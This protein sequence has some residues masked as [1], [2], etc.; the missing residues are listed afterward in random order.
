MV[1]VMTESNNINLFEEVFG[2]VCLNID[3][4]SKYPEEVQKALCKDIPMSEK[5]LKKCIETAFSIGDSENI[6]FIIATYIESLEN[7]KFSR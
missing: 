3:N 1:A 6:I 2:P 5:L 4:L 7:E